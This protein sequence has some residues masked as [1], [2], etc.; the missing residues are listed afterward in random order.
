MAKKILLTFIGAFVLAF[1][2]LFFW[3]QIDGQPLDEV[4]DYLQGDRYQVK[5][6]DSGGFIVEPQSANGYGLLIMHGALIKPAAYLKTAAYFSSRGF[7]VYIP[8]GGWT[9]LSIN[10]VDQ[11]AQ[12]MQSQDVSAWFAIGHS[13]GG[14]S[15]MTLFDQ[16]DLPVNAVA[17]WAAAMPEDF[18]A[19]D[20]PVKFIGGSVDGLLGTERFA[21]MK[22]NYPST[23]EFTEIKGANHKNFAL[24]SHQFFDNPATID[25]NDQI[26]QAQNI[27][28]EFFNQYLK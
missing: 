25:H 1:V 22:K 27:T 19:I 20:L 5:Q 15:S 24:Y 11:A 14:F 13:M 3:Y 12:T 26:E 2:L 6:L 18:S 7:L 16:Y 28:F 23:T 9:R 21:S 17:L 10:A 4:N 8:D